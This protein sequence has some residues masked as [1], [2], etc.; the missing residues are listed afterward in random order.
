MRTCWGRPT[1]YGGVNAGGLETKLGAHTSFLSVFVALLPLLTPAPYAESPARFRLVLI[2]G[3]IAC[4]VRLKFDRSLGLTYLADGSTEPVSVSLSISATAASR[5]DCVSKTL[6]L[7]LG[8]RRRAAKRSS[9]SA[10]T[11]VAGMAGATRFVEC[12]TC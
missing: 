1:L 7:L 8:M 12:A 4:S 9:R 5:I 3:I 2:P 11:V 10:R 6:S